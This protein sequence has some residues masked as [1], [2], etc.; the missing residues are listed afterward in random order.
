MLVEQMRG[1]ALAVQHELDR[2]PAVDEHGLRLRREPRRAEEQRSVGELDLEDSC[3]R[4]I[5]LVRPS[6]RVS[7]RITRKHLGPILYTFGTKPASR[8]ALPASFRPD[9]LFQRRVLGGRRHRNRGVA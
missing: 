4:R 2:E 8:G 9:S 6:L 7:A 1:H 5:L 3:D